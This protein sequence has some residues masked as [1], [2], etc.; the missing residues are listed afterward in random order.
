M[1]GHDCSMNVNKGF[2]NNSKNLEKIQMSKWM[3]K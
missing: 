1:S 3:N 2:I